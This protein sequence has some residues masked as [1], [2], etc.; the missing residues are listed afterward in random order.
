MKVRVVMEQC[1]RYVVMLDI[2]ELAA[3]LG[4]DTRDLS[5]KEV[6]ERIQNELEE[7]DDPSY[8]DAAQEYSVTERTWEVA[9]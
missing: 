7:N 4:I 2:Q 3:E 9:S 6:V 5:V 8:V 1:E